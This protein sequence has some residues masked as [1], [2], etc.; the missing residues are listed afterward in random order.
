MRSTIVKVLTGLSLLGFKTTSLLATENTSL[1]TYVPQTFDQKKSSWTRLNYY[2]PTEGFHSKGSYGLHLGIGAISPSSP[3]NEELLSD[4][5]A[6]EMKEV[7][8]RFFLSKGTAWPVD[9]G[10]SLS[11]LQGSKKA[12]QGGAHIQLTM[13]EGFQMPSVALR[14]S[15]SLLTNYQEIKNLTTDSIELGV[16]YGVIRYVIL[17]ASVRQQ[18]EKGLTQAK[19]D[20]FALTDNELPNWTDQRTVYSWGVNISPFTP[21]IQIGL[22]QSYWDKETQLSIAKLSFLL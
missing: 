21:F 10:A 7:K 6:S 19:G 5:E 8:P 22:E 18:W 4:E 12:M 9:V 17:S 20:L 3:E 16:S 15:R 13:Y 11:L 1:T 2:S 14:A